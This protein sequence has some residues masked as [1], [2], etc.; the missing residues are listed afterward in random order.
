MP[1]AIKGGAEPD[2]RAGTGGPDGMGELQDTR[3]SKRSQDVVFAV[4]VNEFRRNLTDQQRHVLD[5]REA[6]LNREEIA[7]EL[8]LS[9]SA[10]AR[11]IAEVKELARAHLPG[12]EGRF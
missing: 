9:V 8:G 5:L 3:K 11:L 2:E 12:T 7:A 4:A 6:C 1:P 10:I